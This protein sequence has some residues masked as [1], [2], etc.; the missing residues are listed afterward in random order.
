MVLLKA[1]L[2]VVL[3]MSISLL[4]LKVVLLV[5]VV[6]VLL[7][8]HLWLLLSIHIVQSLLLHLLI[9]RRHR[10]IERVH[11]WL[12]F[13]VVCIHCGLHVELPGGRSRSRCKDVINVD[14]RIHSSVGIVALWICRCQSKSEGSGSDWGRIVATFRHCGWVDVSLVVGVQRLILNRPIA[15]R[16]RRCH[17]LHSIL[18]SKRVGLSRVV[19]NGCFSKVLLFSNRSLQVLLLQWCI[20]L[21]AVLSRVVS[22]SRCISLNILLHW[23]CRK[24]SDRLV[25]VKRK[26]IHNWFGLWLGLLILHHSFIIWQNGIHL[27]IGIICEVFTLILIL[28]FV[29][30][31][32]WHRTARLELLIHNTNLEDLGQLEVAHTIN[33]QIVLLPFG[34]RIGLGGHARSMSLDRQSMPT[35]IGERCLKLGGIGHIKEHLFSIKHN[36][37]LARRDGPNDYDIMF[38]STAILTSFA[39]RESLEVGV[40]ILEADTTFGDGYNLAAIDGDVVHLVVGVGCCFIH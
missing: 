7:L 3:L 11:H 37:L 34:I 30:K 31:R 20:S 35:S 28:L 27:T 21:V 36:R 40:P 13:V 17:G 32:Q 25:V 38:R 6:V 24:R 4:L 33:Q 8:L 26:E 22:L 2:L 14:Q 23:S 18:R 29:S 5:T 15:V 16:L 19:V 10:R 39:I 1:C 9:R 12:L